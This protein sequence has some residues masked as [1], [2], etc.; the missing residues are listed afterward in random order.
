MAIMIKIKK[1]K[2]KLFLRLIQA[3]PPTTMKASMMIG[4]TNWCGEY[5]IVPYSGP[6]ANVAGRK[7]GPRRPGKVPAA[8]FEK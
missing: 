2:V 8:A 4:N 6:S 1:T 7:D 3:A 5:V